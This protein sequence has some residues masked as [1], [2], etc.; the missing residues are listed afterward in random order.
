MEHCEVCTLLY[1]LCWCKWTGFLRVNFYFKRFVLLWGEW[2]FVL[3]MFVYLHNQWKEMGLILGW[4]HTC[5]H[6]QPCTHTHRFS[7]LFHSHPASHPILYPPSSSKSNHNLANT[8][9]LHNPCI[10][11]TS[12]VCPHHSSYFGANIKYK[13]AHVERENVHKYIVEISF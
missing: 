12:Q 8:H 10:M 5:V 4:T 6:M 1:G 3:R 2:C 9:C 13:G 7:S 11:E